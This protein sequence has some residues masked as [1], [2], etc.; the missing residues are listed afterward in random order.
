V[1][2]KELGVYV[3]TIVGMLTIIST[4]IDIIAK[5][6]QLKKRKSKRKKSTKRRRKK[7]R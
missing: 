3:S 2:I 6:M 1:G 7:R 5:L 4:T